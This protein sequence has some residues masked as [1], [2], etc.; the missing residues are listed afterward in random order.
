MTDAKV[1][2]ELLDACGELHLMAKISEKAERVV[3]AAAAVRGL[4]RGRASVETLWAEGLKGD[5][6]EHALSLGVPWAILGAADFHI[7]ADN[8]GCIVSDVW[9][10]MARQVHAVGC[11]N[12]C[13]GIEPEA[14]PMLLKA[15]KT[16]VGTGI[17]FGAAE[18]IAEAAVAKAVGKAHVETVRGKGKLV[19]DEGA[20]E[21]V[22]RL[23]DLGVDAEAA[24]K[25][26]L[27]ECIDV[28]VAALEEVIRVY[29][30]GVPRETTDT[31]P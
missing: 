31:Q 24:R 29:R 19:R 2:E 9:S 1:I 28:A 18:G 8:N 16:L 30:S 7:I 26:G 23:A 22:V 17:D 10:S 13:M 21:E 4:R 5:R 20:G 3:N 11:V 25:A 14:V 27:V 12:A 15:C 6:R